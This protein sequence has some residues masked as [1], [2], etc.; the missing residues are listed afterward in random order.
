MDHW[1]SIYL[2][3]QSPYC[4]KPLAKYNWNWLKTWWYAEPPSSSIKLWYSSKA[5]LYIARSVLFYAYVCISSEQQ[6]TSNTSSTSRQITCPWNNH[7][8]KICASTNLDDVMFSSYY[9]RILAIFPM[10]FSQFS[11]F[12]IDFFF[13]LAITTN[14]SSL[15]KLIHCNWFGINEVVHHLFFFFHFLR[16]ERTHIRPKLEDSYCA[17]WRLLETVQVGLHNGR[18]ILRNVNMDA[19]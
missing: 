9:I 6:P 18:D 14:W 3:V 11:Q 12:S 16:D 4:G 10:K 19:V 5:L 13:K 2:S 7:T 1:S 8:N 17:S 15:H